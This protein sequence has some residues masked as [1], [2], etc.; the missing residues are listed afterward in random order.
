M[1]IN[2]YLLFILIMTS[3]SIM[4][5]LATTSGLSLQPLQLDDIITIIANIDYELFHSL[6]YIKDYVSTTNT[7]LINV[8]EEAVTSEHD[9]VINISSSFQYEL[10]RGGEEK[11]KDNLTIRS[12]VSISIEEE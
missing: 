5:A 10:K 8:L 3:M 9:D 7:F 6:Q 4:V 12:R 1:T 2:K 11:S